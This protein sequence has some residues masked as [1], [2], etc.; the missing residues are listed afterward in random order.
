MTE[1]QQVWLAA[2]LIKLHRGDLTE[3]CRHIADKAKADF[4]EMMEDE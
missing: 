1:A 4:E 3:E 2:Y